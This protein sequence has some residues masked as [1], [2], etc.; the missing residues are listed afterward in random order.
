[1]N[2]QGIQG[3]D[4]STW[5]DSPLIAGHV[6]FQVMKDWG[7]RFVI[8]RAG[9][10]NWSDPDFKTSWANAKGVLPRASYFYY[11]NRYPPKDQARK[12]F[13]TI[14]SDLEGM[15]WLDLEDRQVGIYSGWANWYDFL[16]ELK[17]VYP[18]A[19]IGIYTGFFY[20]WDY[21]TYATNAQRDYF[22]PYP[23]WLANYGDNGDP[24]KPDYAR[25]LVPLPW[26]DYLILQSGTPA[27]G[28]AVGVES[29]DVDYNQFNGGEDV[30][31]KYFDVQQQ[32]ETEEPIMLTGKV[33][34]FTNIRSARTQFS[35]DMGDL[36]AGDIV[37]WEEEAV[38]SDGLVWAKLITATHNGAP[39]K[40]T[41]G[42]DVGGR[43]AWVN[44]IEEVTPPQPQPVNVPPYLVAHFA[45]GST[46]KYVPE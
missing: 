4:V 34:K 10:G 41:D 5:Q 3:F 38:G 42:A 46:R 45:D 24:F 23:L 20:W 36:L 1:M 21:I 6:N 32:E 31:K 22:K 14:K 40:C 28:E 30:F 26:L 25:V 11:D 16:E 35:A 9:Q 39:V 2:Y 37:T 27:I 29:K 17:S 13:D 7:A 8:I 19:R 43:F 44:N 12:Y 33:M 15:C 18:G